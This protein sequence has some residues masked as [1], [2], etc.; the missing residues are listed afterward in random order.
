MRVESSRD[1]AADYPKSR[2]LEN[3]PVPVRRVD[4]EAPWRWVM[5]GWADLV[6]MP[7]ISLAYGAAFS[8]VAMAL[9]AGLT[10]LGL[11]SLILA[12]AGGFLLIGP[13]LAVGLYEGS[14]RLE[15][16]EPIAI[17]DIVLSGFRASG[18]L[19]LLGL[20][21]LL[22]YMV[23]VHTALLLFM[24]FMGTQPFG[25]IEEFI[26]NLLLTTRGVSLLV[27]GTIEGAA[28]AALVF[29]ICAVS[30]PMLV[31]RPVGAAEAISVSVRAVW[32]NLKPMLL[33]A[34][35]IAA[36]TIIGFVTLFA[37]LVVVFPLIG[38]AT[39]HAYRDIAGEERTTPPA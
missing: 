17:R 38:H 5:A 8:L 15:A 19:A 1:S 32:L 23:W 35:L 18:Q 27:I 6:R 3:A 11:Q 39:W 9:F 28:L 14:R 10:D 36:L 30:A 13:V 2:P 4:L 12:L 25:P 7:H 20:M 24:V 33:W 29:A 16:G 31:D 26:P 21:L 22:V 37:G 34:A